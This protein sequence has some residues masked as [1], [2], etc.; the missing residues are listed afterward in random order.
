MTDGTYRLEYVRCGKAN[1]QTCAGGPA[2]GPYWY[3]YA[4][5]NGKVI[6]KYVGKNRAGSGGSG[7]AD[8]A[9]G[10]QAS[11]A[12][13]LPGQETPAAPGSTGQAEGEAATA[14]RVREAVRALIPGDPD[15]PWSASEFVSIADLRKML[16]G[17]PR[18]ELDAELGR[19]YRSQEVN[20]VP[21]ENT[22]MMTAADREA[23]LYIGGEGKHMICVPFRR[24]D[25]Q[26][27]AAPAGP[28]PRADRDEPPRSIGDELAASQSREEAAAYL[29]GL[30]LRKAGLLA[31]ATELDVH[32]TGSHTIAEIKRKIV[33]R[34]AWARLAGEATRHG[35]WKDSPVPNLARR[36]EP[37]SGELSSQPLTP[38]RWG[39]FAS[40]DYPVN[41]HEDGVIGTAIQAM[42]T[43]ARLDVD[44][45]PLADVLGKAA[46]DT[47]VGRASAQQLADRVRELRDRL[48]QG[49]ARR[50][51]DQAVSKL[52]AP[53]AP[54]PAIPAVTLDPLR[55][56]AAELHAVPLVRRDP[57]KEGQPLA[58][59]LDDFA[60]GRTGG[61]RL[62]MAVRDLRN[63]RHE[64][65]EGKS[66]IDRAVDRAIAALEDMARTT[67]RKSLHRPE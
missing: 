44:G 15:D 26:V 11:Q 54:P 49:V 1:C 10:S 65:A 50:E 12:P 33:D 43:D 67:G 45:E 66:E 8:I 3:R 58:R 7:R 25:D 29:D 62:I 32:A 28:A 63:R 41:F 47:M 20:L 64:S 61:A 23:E 51:L 34:T 18:A 46:T 21:R 57:S 37:V 24:A 48:P 17:I 30:K 19:M 52:D 35:T 14:A 4:K 59:I 53:A 36:P 22:P 42:G 13:G 56:L 31:L 60:A 39:T 6:S 16:P 5:V 38:N 2:H 27:Q 55:Q 9:A 40:A